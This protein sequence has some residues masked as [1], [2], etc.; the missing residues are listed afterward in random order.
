MPLQHWRLKAKV[1]TI[2]HAIFS[3][4]LFAQPVTVAPAPPFGHLGEKSV[5][6]PCGR[7][8]GGIFL[9]KIEDSSPGEC[10]SRR[11]KQMQHFRA[12][13]TRRAP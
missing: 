6:K 9:G 13:T 8:E 5:G 4:L 1:K 2:S 12:Q 11:P 7:G 10:V 3:L